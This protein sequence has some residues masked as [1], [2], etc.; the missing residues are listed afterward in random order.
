MGP[1]SPVNIFGFAHNYIPFF[2]GMRTPIR[3]LLFTSLAYAVLIGF[4]A[5]GI[6]D[7]LKRI[8]LRR[9]R[10]LNLSVLGLVLISLLIVGNT[11]QETRTAFSTFTLTV[12]QQNAFAWLKQQDD[13]DYRMASP[14]F[15][16]WVYDPE[17]GNIINPTYWTYLHDQENVGGGV[18]ATAVKY[19]GNTLESLNSSLEDGPLDMSPWLSVFNVKYLLVQ[20]THPLSSNIV[21]GQDFEHVWASETVD[22][23]ENLSTQPRVFSFTETNERVIDLFTGNTINLAYGEGTQDAILS[24]STEHHLYQEL[25]VKSSYQ[26]T[27]PRDYLCLEANVEHL[28]FGHDDAIHLTFYSQYDLTDVHA[29]LGLYE[30]DDS[31]YDVVLNSVDGIGKGWNDVSFPLSLLSLR[32]SVDENDQLDFDQIDRLS[33]GIGKQGNSDQPRSFELYF[34]NLSIVTH[35]ID[36]DVAFT[37]IRPGKYEVHVGTRRI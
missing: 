36:D 35:E 34:D 17:A 28:A 8:R 30:K 25:A 4:C 14:P 29:S 19:T 12:D 22:I 15:E 26:L 37:K 31:R 6:T 20:K 11:W 23:Y 18:P 33:V 16:S 21:I 7:W 24:L 3:F 13:G 27:S 32:Y 1:N 10:F 5:K 2:S 9:F